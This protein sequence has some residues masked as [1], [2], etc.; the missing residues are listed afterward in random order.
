MKL[1][2]GFVFSLFI[3]PLVAFAEAQPVTATFLYALSDFSGPIPFNWA[4]VVTDRERKEVYVLYQNTVR[5]FNDSG[6]EIYRFGDDLD[7]GHL[8]DLCVDAKGDIYLLAYKDSQGEI[9][10][11]NYRGEP[12]SRIRFQGLPDRFSHFSPNRMVYHDGRL[13]FASLS[14]MKVVVTNPEGRVERSHD[15][16]PLLELEEKDRGNVELAGFGIDHEGNILFTV[17][18]LFK[19]CVLSPDGNFRWFGRPG[20]TQGKFNVVAGIARDRK[21]HFLVVDKLKCAVLIFDADFRF[22]DQF[23]YRGYRPGN[24]IAPDEI[25]TDGEDRV[26]VTQAARKGVNVYRLLFPQ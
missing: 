18:V 9:I 3:V 24:L 11:C 20:S 26:Y 21:G 13:Y 23:G 2:I 17:P 25:A 22:M 1:C 5:V 6:M 16:L 12:K 8:I 19:A 10:L 14:E 7:L 15:L 4:R